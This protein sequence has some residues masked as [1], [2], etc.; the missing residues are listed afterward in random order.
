[1]VLT[2]T[3]TPTEGRGK[4]RGTGGGTEKGPNERKRGRDRRGSGRE[5]KGSGTR[6]G[7]RAGRPGGIRDCPRSR[8]LI[9]MGGGEGKRTERG[10]GVRAAGEAV[11]T[12][13]TFVDRSRTDHVS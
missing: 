13:G 8:D 12:I 3:P 4:P 5:N 1:M 2:T 7:V 11:N 9:R 10:G 6:K